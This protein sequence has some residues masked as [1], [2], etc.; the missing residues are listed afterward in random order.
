MR[1][2]ERGRGRQEGVDVGVGVGEEENRDC[3][4]RTNQPEQGVNYQSGKTAW[5]STI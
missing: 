2:W 5:R 3:E 1:R 4:S